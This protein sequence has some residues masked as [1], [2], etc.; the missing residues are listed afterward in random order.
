[1]ANYDPEILAQNARGKKVRP[2]M[3]DTAKHMQTPEQEESEELERELDPGLLKA[4]QRATT[5]LP[6]GLVPVRQATDRVNVKARHDMIV[7]LRAQGMHPDRIARAVGVT[8]TTVNG[9]I[10]EYFERKEVELRTSRM[11]QFILLMAEGYL[12]D[13][14]RLT[15]VIISTKNPSAVVSAIRARQEARQ[16]YVDI[17]ADFGFI[18]R[19]ATDVH[20]TGDGVSIDARTQNVI[21]VSEDQLKSITKDILAEKRKIKGEQPDEDHDNRIADLVVYADDIST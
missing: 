9:V 8:R 6:G 13:I 20:V 19:A 5:D 21:V 17:L 15:D 2:Y 4:L 12:E 18:T 3:V 1:M 10:R 16:K 7:R 11:D 14:D